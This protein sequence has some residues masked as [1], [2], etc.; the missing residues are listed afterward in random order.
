MF[1]TNFARGAALGGLALVLSALPAFAGPGISD[2]VVKIGI[3]NDQSG[4]YADLSG[5]GSVVA[6]QMAIDEFGGTV[7]GK[8]I[9]LL[10]ADHQNKADIGLAKAREWFDRAGVDVIADFSNSSVGFAV[11]SLARDRDKVTLIAAASSDFTSKSCSATSAQWVYTSYSNG[12]GLAKALVKSGY[13]SWFLVTVDYAFGQAF[14]A[15]IRKAVS[16]G[17][18]QVLGE[19][20]HPLNTSDM[21]S[22]LLQAQ[23]SKAKVVALASAGADMATGIKQAAEFGIAD[24]SLV[25]PIVF[26][27]D[28]HSLG[29]A[30]AKGL[31][32][33]TAFYWD[34]NEETRAW[35]KKFFAKRN[36]MP[37]MTQAGV[38]SAVRHYLR[39]VE[40]AQTDEGQAV[41]T[42]MKELP[43]DDIFSRNGKVREDGLMLHD[44]YLVEVKQPS[45]SKAPWDYYKILATIPADQAFPSLEQSECPLV[46]K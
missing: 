12:Y 24:Q 45:E 35:S 29:L 30:A 3:L 2:D 38:Y 36:A 33:V 44:M 26:I 46:R 28:V 31:K 15:D 40:A 6:A 16:E 21:S 5:Q 1:R 11:Q 18:G 14:A 22:Y 9:E 7:L 23:S 39:A 8:K 43:V 4:P 34:R 20:R 27:T 13:S 17:K 32:F 37:T 25:A 42:K 41:M 19:V 10:S